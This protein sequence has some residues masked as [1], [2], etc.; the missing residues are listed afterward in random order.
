MQPNSSLL[1]LSSDLPYCLGPVQV[2]V[3][4]ALLFWRTAAVAGKNSAHQPSL[5][6]PDSVRGEYCFK[7]ASH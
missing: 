4:S 7:K 6:L 1:V 2:A 3:R 5:V